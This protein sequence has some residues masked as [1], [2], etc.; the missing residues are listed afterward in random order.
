MNIMILVSCYPPMINAAA[1]LYSELSESLNEMGHNVTVITTYPREEHMVD[2]GHEY[3]SNSLMRK[4]IKG[5]NVKRVPPLLFL[6]K[7][8]GIKQLRIFL[9]CFLF[10]L[11]GV[12]TQRPDVI[13]VYSPPIYMGISGYII[14]KFKK[15]RFVFNMQDIHPK[16]LFDMGIVK[17]KFFM[18]ILYKMEEI[19]YRKAYSFIVYS[20]GN[21]EYLLKRGVNREV[22][23]I[24]NWV[25]TTMMA[26][27]DR[28]NSFRS[29]NDIEDKFIIS[30][31]GSMEPSQGLEVV[32]ETAKLLMEYNDLIFLLAGSGPSKS[33]L[34]SLITN[35]KASNTL[36]L[37]VIPKER[38]VQFL[39]ASDVCLV[40]LS[41]DI[42]PHTVPGKLAAIMACGRPVIAAVNQQ[43]EAAAIIRLAGCGICVEPGN[44]EALSKAVLMLYRD[45]GLRKSMGEKAMM[46][47]NQNFSRTVC[48]KHYEEVLFSAMR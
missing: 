19:C 23:I 47:S 11:R 31:A 40:T 38:Y 28:R 29:E 34:K 45:E 39:N 36:L 42:P 24:P 26:P 48:I 14:S 7:I 5:V 18:R 10:A 21:R 9:S 27:S 43:G 2:N 20:S 35:R 16:V 17:N 22:F 15:T 46:F 41:P 33:L 3:Y 30:F 8:P 13:L 4:V 37:P 44:A 32:V 1:R 25:D 12:C 6:S